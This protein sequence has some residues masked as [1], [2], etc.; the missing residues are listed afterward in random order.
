MCTHPIQLG[1]NTVPCGQCKECR[2]RY[3]TSWAVR[4]V[5]ESQKHKENVFLTLTFNDEHLPPNRS[6]DKKTLQKFLKRFRKQV[7]PAKVR[8]FA[9]GEYGKCEGKRP[10]YHLLVFGI[11]IKNPVFEN[12]RWDYKHQGFWCDCKAWKDERGDSIGNCFIGTITIK[13]AYYVAK[14]SVKKLTGQLGK[15]YYEQRGVIPE[16]S[17]S[18]RR[19]GIGL[20]YLESQQD[21]ILKKNCIGINGSKYPIPRYFHKKLKESLPF[22]ELYLSG[23]S[24]EQALKD[25]KE[26]FKLYDEL[27]DPYT[28]LRDRN[29]Q[30]DRNLQ[31]KQEIMKGVL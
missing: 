3:A 24:F 17:L 20:D 6:L 14:Y 8:F 28:Y 23:Q 13:S 7:Y 5:L 11:G 27:D 26:W 18:S 29:I 4:C 12:L 10:H 30:R 1:H 25:R 19:P 31:K 15:E 9:S 22:Y 2:I 21:T 16:F